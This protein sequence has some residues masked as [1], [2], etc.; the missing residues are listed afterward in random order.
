MRMCVYFTKQ[1][2][3]FNFE[4][5]TNKNNP[6]KKATTKKLPLPKVPYPTY[7]R[8]NKLVETSQ[9]VLHKF[10]KLH[11]R[12]FCDLILLGTFQRVVLIGSQQRLLSPDKEMM[13]TISKIK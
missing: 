4:N 8:Q 11:P 3:F 6:T 13:S 10:Q 1:V 2:Y 5:K 9:Q 7:Q 12:V